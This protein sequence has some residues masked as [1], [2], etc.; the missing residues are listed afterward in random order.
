M[1]STHTG[2]TLSQHRKLHITFKL[3]TTKVR[4]SIATSQWPAV[5]F[6]DGTVPD[7]RITATYSEA[8]IH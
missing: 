5:L 3:L 6:E 2:G 1:Y 7:Y 4:L 8:A